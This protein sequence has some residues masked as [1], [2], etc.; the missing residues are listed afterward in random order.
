MI[1]R[2]F[3]TLRI[4]FNLFISWFWGFIWVVWVL[5]VVS[6]ITPIIAYILFDYSVNDSVDLLEEG[7]INYS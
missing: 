3:N 5:Y 6:V 7:I 1:Y 4:I 2:L